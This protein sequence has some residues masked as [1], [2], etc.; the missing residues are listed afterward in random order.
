MAWRRF[1][2][3]LCTQVLLISCIRLLPHSEFYIFRLL[4]L[5]LPFEKKKDVLLM[6]SR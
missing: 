1:D 4:Y 5:L 2:Q 6:A 3:H